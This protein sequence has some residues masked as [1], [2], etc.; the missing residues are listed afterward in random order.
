MANPGQK[1]LPHKHP[2]E[3][4]DYSDLRPEHSGLHNSEGGTSKYGDQVHGSYKQPWVEHDGVV[5][6]TGDQKIG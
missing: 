3:D 4:P 6:P 2:L 1:H 5:D